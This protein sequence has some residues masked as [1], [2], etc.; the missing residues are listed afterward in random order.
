[1]NKKDAELDEVIAKSREELKLLV[2][3]I[4]DKSKPLQKILK[5]LQV[6]WDELIDNLPDFL[7]WKD[8][9]THQDRYPYLTTIER[10]E[11]N[12]LKFIKISTE[13]EMTRMMN[14]QNHLWLS[15]ITPVDA[16]L[17]INKLPV[18][19]QGQIEVESRVI[20]AKRNMKAGNKVQFEN[21]YAYGH[22]AIHNSK[23][24]QA[25][26]LEFAR[27]KINTVY[28]KT[29]AL[30]KQMKSGFGLPGNSNAD[31]VTIL[32]QVD[33]LIVD[34]LGNEQ[35]N[36]WFLFDI[37]SDIISSRI[38]GNKFTVLFSSLSLSMLKDYYVNHRWLKNDA[39][40]ANSLINK[41]EETSNIFK[42]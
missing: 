41:I 32:R 7:D 4:V 9:W 30:F 36:S 38:I 37:L 26:A 21:V 3:G 29:S 39:H 34:E 2:K 17:Y 25:C 28:L 20:L 35:A 6:T 27:A 12:E 8:N 19:S 33:V 1:M 23:L 10:D 18:I 5:K 24:A 13:N 40:K 31:I 16:T 42:I 22:K 11:N 15:D 14:I